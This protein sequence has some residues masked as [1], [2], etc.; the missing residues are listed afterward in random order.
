MNKSTKQELCDYTRMSLKKVNY[1]LKLMTVSY[2]KIPIYVN[3]YA[4]VCMS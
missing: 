2:E 1:G 4:Y 3:K